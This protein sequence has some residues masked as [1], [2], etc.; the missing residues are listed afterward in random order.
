MG[1]K[2]LPVLLNKEHIE[3]DNCWLMLKNVVM[4]KQVH[5]ANG[6][7]RIICLVSF[8]RYGKRKVIKI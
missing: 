4:H 1:E 7:R 6:K 2:E 8:T 5:Q 3:N